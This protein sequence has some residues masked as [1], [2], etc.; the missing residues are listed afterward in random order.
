[1]G[2]IP[3]AAKA[4]RELTGSWTGIAVLLTPAA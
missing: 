1:M 4:G 2:M 3:S